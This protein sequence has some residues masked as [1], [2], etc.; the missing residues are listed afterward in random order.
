[1]SKKS[2]RNKPNKQSVK[3]N[4]TSTSSSTLYHKL[5]RFIDSKSILF[6]IVIVG[7]SLLVSLLLFEVKVSLG[8]D[9]SA[10]INRAYNFIHNGVFP[11]FQG[12][13][14]PIVLSIPVGIF[15]LKVIL[16]KMLS[17]LF[18]LIHVV[19]F[20][21]TLKIVTSPILRVFTMIL[22][23]LNAYIAFYASSTYSEAFFLMM[24]GIFFLYFAKNF[25]Q[26]PAEEPSVKKFLLLGLILFLMSQTRFA[27]LAVLG[28]VMVYFGIQM[29]WKKV[30]YSVASFIIFYLPFTILLKVL[31][32][33]KGMSSQMETLLMVHPYDASKGKETIGGFLM[34]V[35]ENTNQYIGKAFMVESG[36]LPATGA[37]EDASL[38]IFILVVLVLGF[39]VALKKQHKG[40]IFAYLY[41]GAYAIFTFLAVQ[42]IWNQSRLVVVI[43]PLLWL[44]ILYPIYQLFTLKKMQSFQFAFLLFGFLF[45]LPSVSRTNVKIKDHSEVLQRNL[46]GDKLYGLTPDWINYISMAQWAKKNLPKESYVACRKPT[47][48][49]IYTEG[50]NHFG[51]YKA[52]EKDADVLLQKWKDEGVT[53]IIRASLRR[54]PNV[55]TGHHINTIHRV[56]SVVETKYPGTFKFVKKVG[57]QEEAYLFEINYYGIESK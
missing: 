52:N 22:V 19:L 10:Y 45:I 38:T 14:Y 55:N 54:N 9:D 34:R 7:I 51:I 41:L 20:Y 2:K 13:L 15:G 12:A 40:I 30:L 27:S 33:S 31:K 39:I 1:M 36:F 44:L 17:L 32:I 53:H 47:I 49:F 50:K 21:K 46:A 4:G 24:Q 23:A 43:Y 42:K 29:Q 5:N 48:A 3:S 25:I 26:H 16:L 11:T 18:M 28:A 35:V 6:L 8:G 57:E 37:T 56:L